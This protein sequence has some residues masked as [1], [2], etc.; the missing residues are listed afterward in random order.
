[1]TE[2][3]VKHG[4]L[5]EPII[6]YN[7][8]QSQADEHSL[9]IGHSVAVHTLHE[10]ISRSDIIWSCL[11][12]EVAVTE[13]FDEILNKDI[14][15][16]LFLECSTVLPDVTSRLTQ[17]ILEAGAEFVAMPGLFSLA[18]V[19]GKQ[20]GNSNS[21]WRAKLGKIGKVNLRTS[22]SSQLSPAYQTIPTR[23]VGFLIPTI[24]S[25]LRLIYDMKSVGQAV[26]DLSGEEPAKAS[27]LK[28]IGNVLIMTT[29][30]TVAEAHVFA[31]KTGLGTGHMQNLIATLFPRPPHT[32]YS[33]KM[34]SGDYYQQ[35][36]CTDR[37]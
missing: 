35:E 3:L 22:R 2:N 28:V 10:A 7:R 14:K 23:R 37:V 19:Y 18:S 5:E 21:V 11:Q 9:R 36:V 16:K 4:R 20:P 30:E 8:T 26:V 17:R 24:S 13:M 31:E 27:L 15:G 1:M 25:G 33:A 32:I 12:N 34:V 6:L 29:M